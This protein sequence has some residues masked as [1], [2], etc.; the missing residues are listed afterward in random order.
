[1]AAK[2]LFVF[3]AILLLVTEIRPDLGDDVKSGLKKAKDEI[4]CGLHKVKNWVYKH[5]HGF[6]DDPC[7]KP[8]EYIAPL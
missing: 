1:M 7:H 8:L 2:F 4:H 6:G 5:E 3:V